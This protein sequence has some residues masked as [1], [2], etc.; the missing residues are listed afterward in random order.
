MNATGAGIAVTD[1]NNDRAIDFVIP[2]GANGAAIYLNP[3]EGRFSALPG[4]DFAKEKLPPAVGVTVFDF[5]KDGFMDIAF[6]HA[7]APGITLWRNEGGRKLQRVGLPDLGWKQGWGLTWIDFDNDGWL[8][9]VAV[10]ESAKGG[11]V[12]LL[13]NL[14][15][16][17]W[18][19][20][21]KKSQLD[22]VKLSEP[23][24]VA[25]AD[26]QG[27]GNPD[28]IISQVAGPAVLLGNVGA[29]QN[30]WVQV[31]FGL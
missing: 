19:D 12:R 28:L 3:R 8:D 25:V 18:A 9:L 7:G 29:N 1:F 31:Q 2:G 27:K 11:E 4:I 16:A 23:R 15:D 10:G 6:T 26:L 20:V 30:N 17:G 5:D 21:T 14:G 22:G 24:A 13:R